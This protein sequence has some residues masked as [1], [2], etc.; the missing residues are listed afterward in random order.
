MAK[1]EMIKKSRKENKCSKCGKIIPVGSSYLKAEPYMSPVIIR[2]TTCGLKQYETSGSEYVKTVG[3]IVEDW[4]TTYGSE[5][6]EGVAESISSDLDSLKDDLEGRLDNMPDQLRDADSG[7]LLQ[8]RIDSLESA[9]YALDA[10]DEDDIKDSV[11]YDYDGD[12]SEYVEVAEEDD[13]SEMST[14]E[15]LDS[16]GITD[17]DSFIESETLSDSTKEELQEAFNEALKGAIDEALAE[18]QY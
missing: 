10:I 11:Y 16:L 1:I 7:T 3:A 8:D 18:L 9:I 14:E 5:S 4:E 13:T 6:Y 17:Y 15:I 12:L 2:C